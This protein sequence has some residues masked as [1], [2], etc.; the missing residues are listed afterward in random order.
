MGRWEK[1]N[2]KQGGVIMRKLLR[3]QLVVFLL[4]ALPAIAGAQIY[5][6]EGFEGSWPPTEWQILQSTSYGWEQGDGT[7]YADP[8]V[9]DGTYFARFDVWYTSS[10][11]TSALVTDTVD[12]TAGTNPRLRFYYINEDGSDFVAVDYSTDYGATWTNLDTLGVV[13]A[14]TEFQYSLPTSVVMVR[15]FGV[16]DYGYSNPG[17]DDVVIDETPAADVGPVSFSTVPSFVVEGDA[18][19]FKAWVKN[20]TSSAVSNVPVS[21]S[22]PAESFSSSTTISSIPGNDSVEVTFPDTW[23]PSTSGL[24]DVV[25]ATSLSGDGNPLNDTFTGQKKVWPMGTAFAEDFEG[26]AMPTGWTVTDGNGDGVTWQVGTTSDLSTYTPPDYGTCYAFYSDDDATGSAPPGNE[27]LESPVIDISGFSAVAVSYGWGFHSYGTTRMI[28]AAK[29]FSGG[30]W[31]DYDTVAIYNAS[32]SGVDTFVVIGDSLQI[33]FE[34]QDPDGVWGWASGVDNV[35]VS[36]YVYSPTPGDVVVNEYAPKDSPEWIELYNTLPLP[37]DLTGWMI[38]DG[39]GVDTLSGTISANGFLVHNGVHINLSNSGDEI[40]VIANTGDTI[41]FVAYGVNGGAPVVPSGY[42]GAR[43]PNG[44]DSDDNAADFAIDPTPTPGAANDAPPTALGSSLVINECDNYPS[45]PDDMIELYNPTG[46]PITISSTDSANMWFLT[47]GDGFSSIMIDTV[48]NPGEV[49]CLYE[50][51][52]WTGFDVSSYDVVYLMGPGFV[53]VDQ[54]G[55]KGEYENGSFQ[56]YPDGAGPNDGYDYVSSGGGVTWF[57]RTPT[58]CAINAPCVTVY[59]TGFE[60]PT[61]QDTGYIWNGGSGDVPWM[62]SAGFLYWG[63]DTLNPIDSL[64]PATGDSFLVCAADSLGYDN[65]EFNWWFN[66]PYT[67]MDLSGYASA[68]LSYDLWVHTESNYDYVYVA[69]TD[70]SLYYPTYYIVAGYTGNSGGW[71]HDEVDISAF[72]GYDPATYDPHD[73]IEIALILVSDGSFSGAEGQGFGAAFDNIK[74]EGCGETFAPPTNLTAGSYF[75]GY[76]P[77]SW[78]APTI[79]MNTSY[80]GIS[81]LERPAENFKDK[82]D[83]LKGINAKKLTSIAKE[84]A[85]S[86]KSTM[87]IPTMGRKMNLNAPDVLAY[88]GGS[89]SIDQTVFQ[90]LIYR[91]GPGDA[92]FVLI[93]ST[94]STSYDDYNVTNGEWYHYFVRAQYAAE[95][96]HYVSVPSNTAIG[97]PGAANEVLLLGESISD[98]SF[99]SRLHTALNSCGLTYDDWDYDALGFY[100]GDQDLSQYDYMIW[101]SDGIGSSMDSVD[102]MR[103]VNWIDTKPGHLLIMNRDFAWDFASSVQNA[104]E[105]EL[106]SRFQTTYAGDYSGTCSFLWGVSGDPITDPWATD[107]LTGVF[108]SNDYADTTGLADPIFTFGEG[109]TVDQVAAT[110]YVDMATH[111]KTVWAGFDVGDFDLQDDFNTFICNVISWFQAPIG[112]FYVRGDVNADTAINVTD[113]VYMLDHLFP[114][115]SFSCLRAADVNLDSTVTTTDVSYFL[116]Y[117]FPTPN[118][119]PPVDSCGLNPADT[120]SCSSFPPCGWPTFST[121]AAKDGSRASVG[122][123]LGQAEYRDGYAVVPVYVKSNV[124][125]AAF[126]FR[127]KYD[128]GYDI[129][130]TSHGCVTENYDFFRSYVGNRELMVVSIV[131]LEPSTDGKATGYMEPGRYKVAELRI[132]GNDVPEFEL[133]EAVFSDVYGYTIE[134]TGGT[135]VSEKSSRLPKVFELGQNVPNPFTGRTEIRYALPKDC[136]VELVV[137]SVTGRKVKTLVSGYETAGYKSVTWDGT[138]D[139]GRKLS[140]GLYFYKIKAGKFQSVKRLILLR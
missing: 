38:T 36:E 32:G 71:I 100:P 69:V 9:Y 37:I 139:A 96:S 35:I 57:D 98:T 7:N 66:L 16:S 2:K 25:V 27:T 115:P 94:T 112:P 122:I 87:P 67:D 10:G 55:F 107:S 76:V 43:A 34:F 135:F 54:V 132:R 51:T 17:I 109:Y 79:L 113:A 3:W 28:V 90:Y 1:E 128:D 40:I 13:T 91:M 12:L 130:V 129:E 133:T 60:D 11:D 75:D 29:T 26:C 46:S 52:N 125:V 110:K 106:W 62:R 63:N 73:D 83:V 59:E 80:R 89:N 24:F 126:Q 124:D 102:L 105:A 119:P 50:N 30:V 45:G 134:P 5:L 72:A 4:V 123:E 61:T 41:D 116:T 44:Y 47:D 114:T 88:K 103:V 33:L 42:S 81:L 111:Y 131:S 78:N 22:V 84:G 39:E 74:V 58:P 121:V 19:T 23:T 56:R 48:I 92:D 95:D 31:S 20:F 68:K 85:S 70:V 65:N 6:N 108:G 86:H 117:A 15:F 64:Y 127:L 97:R 8:T 49:L 18:V 21:I 77:L 118:F 137:Y 14:W 138:D 53:Q 99:W 101:F 120:L 104:A 136:N 82:A 140:A 93:D